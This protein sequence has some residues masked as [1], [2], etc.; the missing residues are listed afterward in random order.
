MKLDLEPDEFRRA[1]AELAGVLADYL[2]SLGERPVWPGVGAQ[3]LKDAFDEPVPRAGKGFAAFLDGLRTRVVPGCMAIGSPRY[4]GQFNP[5]P[6][7]IA[8][9]ADLAVSL[10]NQNAGSFLQSPAMTAIEGTVLQ[11]LCRLAGLPAAADGHFTSGGTAA[12]LTALKIARDRL[13]PG[14]R[15][16]GTAA[17]PAAPRVYV[18]EQA[19]FSIARS[20]DLL[21]LGRDALV[22]VDTD[23]NFRM[24]PDA[25]AA[26]LRADRQ[27][28]FV[29]LA[30]VATAGTTPTA[31][32]DPLAEIAALAAAE[33]VHLHVD[34]AYGGA[35]L[36]SDKLRSRLAGIER[37]DSITIDPH[38]WMLMPNEAGCLLVRDR[39]L[40]RGSFGEQPEYLRDSADR[41]QILPDYYRHG[42]Q[43]SRRARAFRVWAA[44]QVHGSDAI[45]AAIERNVELLGYLRA[46]VRRLEN[47]EICH[48][49]D[50]ALLC[51]RFAKPGATPEQQDE[52]NRKIQ[53]QVEASGVAWFATTVLRGRKVLRLNIES[54]RTTEAD[55]DRTLAAIE[56][57]A[58]SL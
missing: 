20:L 18:S 37:A 1:A 5:S 27:R 16:R 19:H 6:I 31:S 40:L 43:G 58:A 49:P 44:F 14:I 15:E 57:A 3:E 24:R 45:A 38:K 17:L 41:H 34:A 51:F 42:V 4:F 9:L 25:L 39:E 7:P 11:W 26:R 56:R 52:L 53:R 30:I 13:A 12:N 28:G 2:G 10:L 22:L 23:A 36:L 50:F 33:G 32:L 46:R 8:A 47:F 54:F 21:G 29:P 48:E 35:A 55:V